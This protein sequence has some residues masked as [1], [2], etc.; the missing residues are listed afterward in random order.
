MT[1]KAVH[2]SQS[3]LQLAAKD[4]ILHTLNEQEQKSNMHYYFIDF[5][6]MKGIL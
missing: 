6:R 1:A 5:L 3:F 4:C 2:G